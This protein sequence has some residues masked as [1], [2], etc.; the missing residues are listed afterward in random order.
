[1]KNTA[2]M[3]NLEHRRN[4]EVEPNIDK[5]ILTFSGRINATGWAEDEEDSG[6]RSLVFKD[7]Q[8]YPVIEITEYKY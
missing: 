1:M 6:L 7:E 3:T 2:N 8:G 5:I 4:Y